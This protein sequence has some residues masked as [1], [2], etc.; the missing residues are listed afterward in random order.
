MFV[1]QS[2]R[3]AY[4]QYLVDKNILDEVVALDVRDQQHRETPPIGRLAVVEGVLDM[5]QVFTI[6]NAQGDSDQRFGEV[7]IQ[8]G[9]MKTQQL[10]ILLDIQRTKRPGLNGIIEGMGL[11][12]AKTLKALRKEF[13]SFINEMVT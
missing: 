5:K 6:V 3:D 8:L 13:L 10:L 1:E 9:Y 11:A 12:D 4:L 2:M 7:A